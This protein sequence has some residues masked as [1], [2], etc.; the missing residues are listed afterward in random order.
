VSQRKLLLPLPISSNL[1]HLA[2]DNG[3]SDKLRRRI[4]VRLRLEPWSNERH[5]FPTAG[6][7]HPQSGPYRLPP[8]HSAQVKLIWPFGP[9]AKPLAN[10]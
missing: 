6:G 8:V 10:W 2:A 4:P 1:A 9:R 3:R 7:T 5:A